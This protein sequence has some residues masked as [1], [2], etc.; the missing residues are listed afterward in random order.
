MHVLDSEQ[1]LFDEVGGLLLGQAL[2]LRDEVKQLAPAQSGRKKIRAF[3]I[4][5]GAA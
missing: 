1:D 4:W 2:L 3:N 5:L